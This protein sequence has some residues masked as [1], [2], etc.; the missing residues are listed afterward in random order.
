LQAATGTVE[1]AGSSVPAPD[2]RTETDKKEDESLEAE[3]AES[4]SPQPRNDGPVV[5]DVVVVGW[6]RR[7]T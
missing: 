5:D 1:A 6:V 3:V 7:N 4:N 2:A